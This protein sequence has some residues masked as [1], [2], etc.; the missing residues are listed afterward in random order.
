MIQ[1]PK[2]GIN[3]NVREVIIIVHFVIIIIMPFVNHLVNS[4]I[5]RVLDCKCPKIRM[6][7]QIS[8]HLQMANIEIVLGAVFGGQKKKKT[9]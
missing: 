8:G 6:S 3:R 9:E 1:D 5:E 4:L 2:P 7:N